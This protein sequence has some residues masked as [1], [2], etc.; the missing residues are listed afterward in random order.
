MISHLEAENAIYK[1]DFI[2]I[3]ETY[4]DSSVL[5]G[6][7]KYTTQWLQFDQDRPSK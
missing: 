5:K 2:Y 6:D 7:K 4:F 3:S 1:H